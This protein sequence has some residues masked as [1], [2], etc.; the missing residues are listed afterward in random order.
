MTSSAASAPTSA[1]APEEK[2]Q[3]YRLRD[4]A[5][6]LAQK[7]RR[8]TAGELVF[9]RDRTDVRVPLDR[10]ETVIGR[11]A[12][13]DIVLNEPAASARHA[14]IVRTAGGYFELQDL[15]SANGTV[16]D[17]ERVETMTLLDGDTF[18]IGDT[19]FAIVVAPIVGE[20]P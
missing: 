4:M 1:A 13:C 19:R 9:R 12:T 17:G 7:R 11:D 14:R 15:R 20:E 16:V 5:V 6:R 18:T 3:P 2:T 8:T 10:S